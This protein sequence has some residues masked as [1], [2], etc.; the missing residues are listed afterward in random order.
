MFDY[1]VFY[2]AI[3]RWFEDTDGAEEKAFIDEVLL[4]WNQ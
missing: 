1:N 3:V 2:N 4:L